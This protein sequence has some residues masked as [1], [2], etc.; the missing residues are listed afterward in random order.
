[1][2]LINRP[3][4]TDF[5]ELLLIIAPQLEARVGSIYIQ[6]IS[7]H[8]QDI[9]QLQGTSK[10]SLFKTDSIHVAGANQGGDGKGEEPEHL[11]GGQ[12]SNHI[13]SSWGL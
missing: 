10:K 4:D 3:K 7:Y 13:E 12:V 6:D 1:M 8:T 11:R 9:S 2:E 5:H